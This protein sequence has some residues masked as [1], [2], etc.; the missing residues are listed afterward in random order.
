LHARAIQ[1]LRQALGAEEQPNSAARII[2]DAVVAFQ[3]KP[4]MMKA[5]LATQPIRVATNREDQKTMVATWMRM[6]LAVA[7][8]RLRLRPRQSVLNHSAA[9]GGSGGSAT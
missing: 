1:R 3:Q 6:P 9:T 8:D 7:A 2:R 4:K 5:Q